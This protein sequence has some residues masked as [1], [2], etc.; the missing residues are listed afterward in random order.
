SNFNESSFA[1]EADSTSCRGGGH[2]SQKLTADGAKAV[3]QWQQE[4]YQQGHRGEF[5][6]IQTGHIFVCHRA[7]IFRQHLLLLSILCAKG[8]GAS[9]LFQV[10]EPVSIG[11]LS[12]SKPCPAL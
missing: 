7:T 5:K 1:G 8:G 9:E 2:L 4:T 12:G 6:L 10:S 11:R 3:D